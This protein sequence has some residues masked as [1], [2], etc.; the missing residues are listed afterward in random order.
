MINFTYYWFDSWTNTLA[1]VF[2]RSNSTGW[3]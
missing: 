1:T 2:L 3:C